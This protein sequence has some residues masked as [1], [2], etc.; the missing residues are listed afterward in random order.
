MTYG[1]KVADNRTSRHFIKRKCS[2]GRSPRRKPITLNHLQLD[3]FTGESVQGALDDI[4]LP[5]DGGGLLWFLQTDE[6][7][8]FALED[9]IWVTLNR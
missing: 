5:L 2:L 4:I 9:R 6:L 1:H 8:R 3:F 7:I